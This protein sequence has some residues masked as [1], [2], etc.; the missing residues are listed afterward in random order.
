MGHCHTRDGGEAHIWVRASLTPD[1]Q[2]E[3][4]KRLADVV[5]EA[6]APYFLVDWPAEA[7]VEALGQLDGNTHTCITFQL[8]TSWYGDRTA[9]RRNVMVGTPIDQ[10]APSRGEVLE[11][12][13]ARQVAKP[14]A[15][16]DVYLPVEAVDP[17]L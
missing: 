8:L 2:G 17:E 1:E 12:L 13:K 11:T 3:E 7:E 9:R 6:R 15:V 4:A 10:S 14:E 5:R 16:G